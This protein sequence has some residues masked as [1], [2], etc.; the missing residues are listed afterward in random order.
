MVGCCNELSNTI[1]TTMQMAQS[2]PNIACSDTILYITSSIFTY[3]PCQT[4]WETLI[5]TSTWPSWNTFCLPMSPSAIN[6]NHQPPQATRLHPP[7]PP[8]CN[9]APK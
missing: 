6:H 3:A 4:I 5:D 8:Y 1:L 7:S 2:T 9:K